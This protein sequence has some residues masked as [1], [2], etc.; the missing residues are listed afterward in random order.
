MQSMI[1]KSQTAII[2]SCEEKGS[3]ERGRCEPV[4]KNYREYY[5]KRLDNAAKGFSAISDTNNTNVFRISVVLKIPVEGE[6]LQKAV[7]LALAEFP[8]FNVKQRKGFFWYYLESNFAKPIVQEEKTFPCLRI[9]RIKNNGFM[10]RVSYFGKKINLEVFHSLTDGTGGMLFLSHVLY[11]FLS[12]SFPDKTFSQCEIFGENAHPTEYEEDSFLKNYSTEQEKKNHNEPQA[13]F[14]KGALLEP[15][16]TRVITGVLSVKDMLAVSKNSGVTMTQYL[17]AALIQAIYLGG[18][19]KFR[20]DRPIVICIPVNLRGIYDSRTLGNFFSYIN[21]G[22]RFDKD[23]SF[24]EILS[25]VKG[26]FEDQ[27]HRD[28]LSQKLR[29]NVEAERNT[30]IRFV[31]LVIKK[32]G[33]TAVHRRGERS[34]T[35]ALSNLG[36]AR[37]PEDIAQFIER[38]DILVSISSLKAVKVGVVSFEDALSVTFTSALVATDIQQ[39]FFSLLSSRGIKIDIINNEV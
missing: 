5:W 33:L 35:S 13:H 15:R 3:G 24:E 10:F 14:I 36:T 2:Q 32:I 25:A 28:K 27:L 30:A 12:Q 29:Y 20:R 7:E 37:F 34:Q 21:I 1:N 19:P 39:H 4:E 38:L 23:H 16:V 6:L 18:N 9:D 8:S 22:L 26:Q 11:H 17:T 31:P